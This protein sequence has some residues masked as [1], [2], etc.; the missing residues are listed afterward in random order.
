VVET[1]ALVQ[2]RLGMQAARE[3]H[4]VVVRALELILV[5]ADAHDAAVS[6]YLAT[7]RRDLSLVDCVSFELM[8]TKGIEDAFAFDRHFA[9]RG[10]RLIP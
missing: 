9:S 5:D 2:R 6:A 8:R 4:D 7:S 1:T 10:F 3:L